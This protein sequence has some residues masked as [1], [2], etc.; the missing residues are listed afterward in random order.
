VA[1]LLQ[2]SGQKVVTASATSVI[3][4]MQTAFAAVFALLLL[5]EALS[6]MEGMGG[7]LILLAAILSSR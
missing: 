3:L 5:G 6:P 2:Q 1:D 4:A 7:L